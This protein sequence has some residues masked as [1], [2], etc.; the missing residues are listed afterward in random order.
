MAHPPVGRV[1]GDL[2]ANNQWRHRT[3]GTRLKRPY[4]LTQRLHAGKR[5]PD[6]MAMPLMPTQNL[7]GAFAP[8]PIADR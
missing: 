5:V 4:P 1:A 8:W 3:F 7:R 6:R 2:S